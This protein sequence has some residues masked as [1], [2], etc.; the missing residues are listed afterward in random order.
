[1]LYNK[2][3]VD[4]LIYSEVKHIAQ[5]NEQLKCRMLLNSSLK[6]LNLIQK[7]FC[8]ILTVHIIELGQ[9]KVFFQSVT[10][11]TM[12][13]LENVLSEYLVPVHIAT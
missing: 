3:S 8:L 2:C 6:V 9:V 7:T 4:V 1:M 12:T 5:I 13:Y 11:N 10:A